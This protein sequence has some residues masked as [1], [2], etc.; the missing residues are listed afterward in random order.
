[1]I[2]S[3]KTE[4]G[5]K[6]IGEFGP[7]WMLMETQDSVYFAQRHGPWGLVRPAKKK[8]A[9]EHRWIHLVDDHDFDIVSL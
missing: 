2:L 9:E 4:R 6:W 3:A 7:I 8:F 1:M 5:Q